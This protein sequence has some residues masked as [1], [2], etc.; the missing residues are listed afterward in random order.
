MV[1]LF[2]W[3]CF[4]L[5]HTSNKSRKNFI[6]YLYKYEILEVPMQKAFLRKE[7][8]EEQH[9]TQSITSYSMVKGVFLSSRI[10]IFYMSK[11][12]IYK[13]DFLKV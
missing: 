2:I 8:V 6:Y 5:T 7:M 4:P 13:V 10:L 12:I 1:A 3:L 11:K 9:H